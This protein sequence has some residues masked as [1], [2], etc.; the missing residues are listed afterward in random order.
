MTRSGSGLASTALFAGLSLLVACA[1]PVALRSTRIPFETARS[2]IL[3][4]MQLGEEANLHWFILDSAVDPS[5]IDESLLDLDPVE[6]TSDEAQEAEGAG[7]GEGL[8]VRPARV[9][10]YSIGGMELFRLEA[11]ATDLSDFG[12]SLGR[13]LAGILGHSFLRDKAVRIDYVNAHVDLAFNRRELPE[14]T[15]PPTKIHRVPLR[16]M[17]KT[18]LIPVLDL[19]VNGETV[20]V[21]LDTGSSLG[22]QIYSSAVERLGLET[23]RDHAKRSSITGARG[24]AEIRK[25]ILDRVVLGPFEEVD[26]PLDFSERAHDP[27]QR[28]GNVGNRFLERFVLTLDYVD[29]VIIFEQ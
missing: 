19:T 29:R 23:L 12:N 9:H 28:Q 17:T 2:Q 6:L 8:A 27:A 7:D 1:N 16:F 20:R 5:V 3:V 4:P 21:S 10:R 24:Q 15:A 18:D 13:P 11:V 22:I 25:A 26:V 14:P